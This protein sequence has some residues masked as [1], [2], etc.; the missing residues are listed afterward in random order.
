[1][2][3]QSTNPSATSTP[4]TS[5]RC[6]AHI[7]AEKTLHHEGGFSRELQVPVRSGCRPQVSRNWRGETRPGREGRRDPARPATAQPQSAWGPVVTFSGDLAGCMVVAARYCPVRRSSLAN[8]IAISGVTPPLASR[9]MGRDAD[10][11]AARV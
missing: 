11:V 9:A 8:R 7:T 4:T 3:T 5:T 10:A 1:M 6:G 2:E